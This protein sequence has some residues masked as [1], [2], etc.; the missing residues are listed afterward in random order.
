MLAFTE[1]RSRR[2]TSDRLLATAVAMRR[3]ALGRDAI[4][5]GAA[6]AA[7]LSHT[8]HRALYLLHLIARARGVHTMPT[9]ALRRF[10][11]KLSSA[12]AAAAAAYPDVPERVRACICRCAQPIQDFLPP[13]SL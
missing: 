3:R 9:A 10:A 7:A 13:P 8:P 5:S 1:S 2:V 4:A 11:A 12:S 6:A